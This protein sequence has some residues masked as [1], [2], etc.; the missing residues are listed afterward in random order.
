MFSVDD[1]RLL[2]QLGAQLPAV[3]GLN[4]RVFAPGLKLLWARDTRAQTPLIPVFPFI[5]YFCLRS[6]ATLTQLLTKR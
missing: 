2:Q 5:A 6:H 1:D 3:A 4:S